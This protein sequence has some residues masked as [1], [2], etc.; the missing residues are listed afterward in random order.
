MWTDSHG[1]L[2]VSEWNAGQLGRYDPRSGEWQEWK[3][4]GARPM[5]Y[6]VY[7]D[8][9]DTVWLSDWGS[10][11]LVRFDP[12]AQTFEQF[13]MPDKRGRH[14]PDHGP[15]RRSVGR[16][17]R[18]EPYRCHSPLMDANSAEQVI[19]WVPMMR[20]LVAAG[21]PHVEIEFRPR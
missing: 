1:V 15:P 13:A 2:W 9:Q 11:A 7:V 4:P 14:S 3:L 5:A 17:I 6:A 16:R 18:Q 12:S 21:F 10:N 20:V 19:V 8:E